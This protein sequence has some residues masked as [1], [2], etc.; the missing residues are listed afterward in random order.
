MDITDQG[1]QME[2]L[3]P[4]VGLNRRTIVVVM[5]NFMYCRLFK[6]KAEGTVGRQLI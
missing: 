4:T 3:L 2:P 6:T 5:F 1:A